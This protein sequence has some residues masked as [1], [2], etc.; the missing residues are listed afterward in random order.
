MEP[1]LKDEDCLFIESSEPMTTMYFYLIDMGKVK[2]GFN[3][4][5]DVL[6]GDK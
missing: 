6:V 4:I 5:S 3:E 2:D 1:I